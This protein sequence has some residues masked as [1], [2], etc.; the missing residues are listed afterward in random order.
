M[1]TNTLLASLRPQGGKG[2]SRRLRAEGKIPAVAYGADIAATSL[3]VSPKELRRLLSGEHGLN[4]VVELEVDGKVKMHTLVVDYQVHPV[5]RAILHADFKK[6]DLDKPVDVEVTLELVGKSVGVTM[7]GELHQIFKKLPV[8]CRPAQIPVKLVHDITEISLDQAAH[9]KELKLPEGVE[10]LLPP[11][12][13]IATVYTAKKRKDEE[14]AAAEGAAA[15]TPAGAS[16]A[17]AA[18]EESKDK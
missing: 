17:P 16:K 7:G 14:E 2:P 5:T 18:K 12:R 6:I 15:A 8:R 4:T 11:E 1:T 10:V 9:V 3:A 13:T